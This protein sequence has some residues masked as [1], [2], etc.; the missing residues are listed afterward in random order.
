MDLENNKIENIIIEVFINNAKSILIATFYRPPESSK[1]LPNDF[2]ELFEESLSL[3]CAES[4]EVIL[5]GDLNVN[6]LNDKDN[7]KIKSIIHSHGFYQ[8][9]KKPTRITAESKTLIDIIATNNP[10]SISA[11]D[12]IAT[13]LSDHDMV[14]CVRKLHNLKFSPKT[15]KCRDYKKYNPVEMNKDFERVNWNLVLNSTNVNMAVNYFNNIVRQI[16]D[17]HAPHIIKRV[18]GHPCPWLNNDIKSEMNTRDQM[19]RKARKYNKEDD[20]VAYKRLRNRCT[21][22]LKQAKSNYH[23]N[24]INEN[25]FNPKGFWNAVKNIFPTKSKGISGAN[26][27]S[28][29]KKDKKKN[30]TEH[31]REYFSSVVQKLKTKTFYLKNCIWKPPKPITKR[32]NDIFKFKYVSHVFV[33]KYIKSLKRKK[34]T[35]IDEL[36]P[37]MLKDCV[38]NISLPLHHIINLSITTHTVPTIWKQAKVIPVYQDLPTN[39]KTI[40]QYQFYPYFQRY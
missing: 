14:G 16:F 10:A 33:K 22:M 4:K 20:W 23:K 29:D 5:L 38:E 8:I 9:I 25:S 3:Y 1:Y 26:I 11:S 7:K 37:G 40:V 15:I 35:G 13:S 21:N 39:L 34:A 18:K 27:P 31:F 36:P 12:V 30:S 2:N 28:M 17:K 32:T 24:L 19:L 6:Y